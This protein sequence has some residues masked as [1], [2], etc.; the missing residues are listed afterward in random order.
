MCRC[1][2]RAAGKGRRCALQGDDLVERRLGTLCTGAA[3]ASAFGS[4]PALAVA[5]SPYRLRRHD[6]LLAKLFGKKEKLS[7]N[8]PWLQW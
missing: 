7:S 6:G 4:L 2:E 1:A 5:T 3:K 8:K